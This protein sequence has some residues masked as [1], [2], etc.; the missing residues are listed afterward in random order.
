M[1]PL[2]PT[3]AHPVSR[4]RSHSQAAEDALH[5]LY[6]T[7]TPPHALALPSSTFAEGDIFAAPAGADASYA[8]GELGTTETLTGSAGR[9]A[10]VQPKRPSYAEEL[11]NAASS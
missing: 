1:L 3:S 6:L 5:R 8:P 10:A 2:T 4:P 7:R 11:A 9:T